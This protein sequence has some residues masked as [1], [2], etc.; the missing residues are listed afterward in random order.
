[1]VKIERTEIAG[2]SE[3]RGLD[4]KVWDRVRAYLSQQETAGLFMGSIDELLPAMYTGK[5]SLERD[6]ASGVETLKYH[7]T[8]KKKPAVVVFLR[9]G[10]LNL[11][12]RPYLVI[13]DREAA[14][15]LF[16]DV[17]A[18]SALLGKRPTEATRLRFEV[19]ILA[20]FH[21]RAYFHD[22]ETWQKCRKRAL[23][24]QKTLQDPKNA[25]CMGTT[26]R[27]SDFE[28]LPTCIRKQ[29]S[30][31]VGDFHRITRQGNELFR[32]ID[33]PTL[34]QSLLQRSSLTETLLDRV[35]GIASN[36]ES[37]T[38]S[39]T[40]CGMA[41]IGKSTIAAQ[42]AWDEEFVPRL[43]PG[44]VVWVSFGRSCTEESQL[45]ERQAYAIRMLVSEDVHIES[46]KQGRNKLKEVLSRTAYLI[47]LD[48]VWNYE[49]LEAFPL[50][51]TRSC[52][53][54]T[55]KNAELMRRIEVAETPLFVTS[56]EECE[57]LE[58][59]R[60]LI[61]RINDQS[62]AKARQLNRHCGGVPL[63]LG[64]VGSL[65]ADRGLSIENIVSSLERADFEGLYG[66]VDVYE[67]PPDVRDEE[68][69]VGLFGV[70]S[71]SVDALKS[72]ER[73]G[74]EQLSAAAPNTL[75]PLPALEF[76]WHATPSSVRSRVHRLANRHLIVLDEE[77]SVA[78]LH[79]LIH[80]YLIARAKRDGRLV[81]HHTDI[82][83]AYAGECTEGG[84][85][86]FN[87]EEKVPWWEM[88]GDGY[89]TDNLVWHLLG[90][91]RW[92]AAVN[93]LCDNTKWCEHR[94]KQGL[95]HLLQ[96]IALI[97]SHMIR[98]ASQ[99]GVLEAALKLALRRSQLV[100]G[101]MRTPRRSY[102]LMTLV[103]RSEEAKRF[104]SH[105]GG[106]GAFVDAAVQISRGL[107]F[108][109]EKD[110][111]MLAESR[112]RLSVI[113]SKKERSRCA[114]LLAGEYA[115]L[116]D[117]ET[118]LLVSKEV[119][120]F[121][122]SIE[123]LELLLEQLARR[124]L[125]EDAA[126]II[127]HAHEAGF[128]TDERPKAALY[129]LEHAQDTQQDASESLK[130][131][132][133][134]SAQ[135]LRQ[136]LDRPHEPERLVTI[137][138]AYARAGCRAVAENILLDLEKP[139]FTQKKAYDFW[140]K[141]N[142][143]T[144]ALA[145][146]SLGN[147]RKAKLCF[148]RGLEA[149]TKE[150]EADKRAEL[151]C[152]ALI[153]ASA[154]KDED[155]VRKIKTKVLRILANQKMR[156]CQYTT[157]RAIILAL[158]SCGR[159]EEAKELR[160]NGAGSS[161]PEVGRREAASAHLKRGDITE[162][163]LELKA[164][165]EYVDEALHK[166]RSR[167]TSQMHCFADVALDVAINYHTE[168]V[169]KFFLAL[170]STEAINDLLSHRPVELI[171]ALIGLD[172]IPRA[173]EYVRIYLEPYR[174]RRIPELV[175]A[176]VSGAKGA[177]GS[178]A[179]EFVFHV[180]SVTERFVRSEATDKYDLAELYPL[181]SLYFQC[182]R[183]DTC[184]RLLQELGEAK[185]SSNWDSAFVLGEGQALW[186]LVQGFY[187]QGRL[188]DAQVLL[189]GRCFPSGNPGSDIFH[190]RVLHIL[191]RIAD[192]EEP[193]AILDVAAKEASLFSNEYFSN[194]FW[195]SL[196][197]V[198]SVHGPDDLAVQFL[199]QVPS[200]NDIAEIKTNLAMR[201]VEAH[202]MEEARSYALSAHSIVLDELSSEQH[203]SFWLPKLVEA[204]KATE[205]TDALDELLK[206]GLEQ[207]QGMRTQDRTRHSARV[208]L[209]SFL[210][211]G[212]AIEGLRA[213]TAIEPDRLLCAV[214]RRL[215]GQLGM[216]GEECEDLFHE[217]I[218]MM[219]WNS[220][221]WGAYHDALI[222]GKRE[223]ASP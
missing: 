81:Q 193:R 150:E 8:A 217:V 67:C 131:I 122:R 172:E 168:E 203:F 39:T 205:L 12:S 37:R 105:L 73:A 34:P 64:I 114:A 1:V 38:R 186:D 95:P 175:R 170:C 117:V 83:R 202:D 195:F 10:A 91:R 7:K 13:I 138:K 173:S 31:I 9:D 166:E 21:E 197:K 178:G 44:G 177:H 200:K 139:L 160:E 59:L 106:S 182:G 201:M 53:V 92:Q 87:R 134:L 3:T 23:V 18:I 99:T 77:R 100:D 109:G 125:H 50:E 222:N 218:E 14:P 24:V 221:F 88:D 119:E 86:K 90:S 96:D 35:R 199:E 93:L 26:L 4:A 185:P 206:V 63:A 211:A 171:K 198:C 29:P 158:I 162:V 213:V 190:E 15:E 111:E 68:G 149:I 84:A 151:L 82:L 180:C 127:L 146:A 45:L 62:L 156:L 194:G 17:K 209:E 145:Y 142:L 80:T 116:D 220:P 113:P 85:E 58:F 140:N 78:T 108:K 184:F 47:V 164:E 46:V 157:F 163:L 60:N 126:R 20:Y 219:G 43:F 2:D 54:A 48:D 192:D 75:I 123:D 11:S 215:I 207:W 103:G 152:L 187:A 165:K 115:A 33:V 183:E 22:E 56:L 167:L 19:Y 110:M 153:V 216:D 36:Q 98:E 6:R 94:Y 102:E 72:E 89:L 130:V 132:A 30:E 181:A 61:G 97:E 161:G 179:T 135:R 49:Q 40:L 143:L 159:L 129:Y 79:D 42:V 188:K 169:R 124:D 121:D 223:L 70:F 27:M 101:P 144:I 128:D 107:R 154:L 204:L 191:Q 32:R 189:D 55:S 41:G 196:A 155:E 71:L 74:F 112:Q 25:G 212:R 51:G 176:T 104:A 69:M 28:S 214:G 66:L 65:I 52:F 76:I 210:A 120:D 137:C 136:S 141:R 118:A 148:A 147:L 174:G 208:L 133:D 5:G 16:V 57:A